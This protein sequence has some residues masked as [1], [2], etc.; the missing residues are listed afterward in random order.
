MTQSSIPLGL[1]Q[2][3]QVELEPSERVR[4]SDQPVPGKN[5]ATGTWFLFAFG[6]VWTAFAVFWTLGASGIFALSRGHG[7]GGFQVVS[8]LFACF[9]I[10]F[11]LIGVWM[12]SSPWR[13]TQKVQK[14]A[15]GTAYVITD[16]R[17][18]IFDGGFA[19]LGQQSGLVAM[20]P[21][22]PGM[23][24]TLTGGALR[25]QS[26]RPEQLR[27]VTRVQRPDGSGDLIFQEIPGVGYDTHHHH[28][29]PTVQQVGFKCV[30][31]VLEVERLLKELSGRALGPS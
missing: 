21:K 13:I 29:Y 12:V 14:M 22:L 2:Q 18:I 17:A 16:R 24:D 10:P 26:F 8:L 11:I 28:H 3:I 20:M 1:R 27:N 6:L 30:P 7:A 15:A 23:P 19:A 9:G 31:Q 4:W 25:V 5:M